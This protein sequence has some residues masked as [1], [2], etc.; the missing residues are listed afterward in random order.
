MPK[1]TQFF[2]QLLLRRKVVFFYF[3]TKIN[4]L[5]DPEVSKIFILTEKTKVPPYFSW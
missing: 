3:K 1:K 5:F 4:F 2:M